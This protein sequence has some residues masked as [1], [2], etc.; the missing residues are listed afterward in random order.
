MKTTIPVFLVIIFLFLLLFVAFKWLNEPTIEEV[1]F[2]NESNKGHHWEDIEYW[3]LFRNVA[4]L[5]HET[6]ALQKNIDV[7]VIGNHIHKIGV[8]PLLI[9]DKDLSYNF[10]CEGQIML[11]LSFVS[12]KQKL[13]QHNTAIMKEDD[14]ADLVIID[15]KTITELYS[16][17]DTYQTTLMDNDRILL[18]MKNGAVEKDVLVKK[19]ID[20]SRLQQYERRQK[21][22]QSK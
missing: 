8:N 20:S 13:A 15:S 18:I 19:K 9:F 17:L 21:Q 12:S 1:H 22:V 16:F 14:K 7:L 10:D 3:V 6:E 2:T 5:T 4:L 11:P